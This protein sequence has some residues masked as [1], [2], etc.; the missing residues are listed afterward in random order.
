M[1]TSA[2]ALSC[3]CFKVLGRRRRNHEK[4]H[5]KR[6]CGWGWTSPLAIKLVAF[7]KLALVQSINRC[8]QPC[9][10]KGLGQVRLRRRCCCC[11]GS[12]ANRVA[13]LRSVVG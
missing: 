6:P 10:N 2:S 11:G 1:V 13:W 9:T 7:G 4:P 12:K 8:S 3:V 5:R